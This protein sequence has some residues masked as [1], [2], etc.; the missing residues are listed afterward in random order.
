M[1]ESFCAENLV[2]YNV[3]LLQLGTFGGGKDDF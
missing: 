3:S 2:P 1:P